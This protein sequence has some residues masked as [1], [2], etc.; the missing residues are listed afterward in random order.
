MRITKFH[1]NFSLHIKESWRTY[2][3][4]GEIVDDISLHE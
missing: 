2:F 3:E 4:P 1:H